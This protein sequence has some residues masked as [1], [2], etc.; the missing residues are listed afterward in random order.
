M[1]T[2]H[3][4][5]AWLIGLAGAA[6]AQSQN[7]IFNYTNFTSTAELALHGD[8]VRVIDRLRLT[9]GSVDRAGG[10]WF[11]MK[12][13]LQDGFETTFQFQITGAGGD[14]PG[15]GFAFVI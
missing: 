8:A 2:R 14:G 12:R 13:F 4:L 7:P 9:P 15:E 10:V 6:A 1:K 3:T 11:G 5:L